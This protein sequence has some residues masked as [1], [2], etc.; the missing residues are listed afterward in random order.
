MLRQ[1]FKFLSI[2]KRQR[3]TL[4]LAAKSC[5]EW[6]RRE[7]TAEGEAE[8]PLRK[9]TIISAT[10]HFSE[11]SH[12]KMAANELLVIFFEGCWRSLLQDNTQQKNDREKTLSLAAKS[13]KEWRRRES[14]PRPNSE[15]KSFLHVYS[16][17]NP[18]AADGHRQPNRSPSS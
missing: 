2:K 13:C 14:N 18:S 12:R 1:P 15:P 4:S 7:S 11:H 17:F 5:K 9:N 16:A 8:I 10:P 6:R 3:K